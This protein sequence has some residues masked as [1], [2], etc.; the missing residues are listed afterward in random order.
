MKGFNKESI[1]DFI[2]KMANAIDSICEEIKSLLASNPETIENID[3]IF[4][5][6]HC[7]SDWFKTNKTNITVSDEIIVSDDNKKNYEQQMKKYQ[8]NHYDIPNYHRMKEYMSAKLDSKA[9]M[10]MLS[11]ISS[12][13]T[14]FPINWES[15]IFIRVSKKN[16]NLL[17]FFITG[18]KDTPYENGFFEFH[19]SFPSD[20]PNNPPKVLLNTTGK[21]T[22][23][24]N[25][26]LYQCG[27]VCLSLLGTWSGQESE[28]WN[29]NTSTFIQVP[30]SIQSLI[31]IE[32]PY[33][34]EPGYERQMN[35][36]EG[37]TQ[38]QKYNEP[39]FIGT[40]K[41]TIIDMINNPPATMEEPIKLHFKMKKDEIINTT[42]KWL[43]SCI[44]KSYRAELEQLRN[45]MIIL[46][47]TL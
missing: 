9:T 40:I 5:L 21:D 6:F 15:S 34:N 33:F 22:I 42:K 31:L 12:F 17:S 3:N 7:I 19:A 18:P 32:K 27:K 45:E 41:W 16:I 11:E 25:P 23:R 37:K 10:R 36:I 29:A 46:L 38:S 39:L 1:Q 14:V 35:T 47:N 44:N 26:N 43:D 2:N 13:K 8:F 28:K 24:F 20:Y 30:I 4:L